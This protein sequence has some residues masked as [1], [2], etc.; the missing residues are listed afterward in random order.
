MILFLFIFNI[1]FLFNN[2]N[3]MIFTYF[4]QILKIIFL[5]MKII[6]IKNLGSLKIEL[7]SIL[8][9][10]FFLIETIILQFMTQYFL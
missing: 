1:L 10:I 2:N 6:Y 5:I 4:N 3:F 7:L 8:K 9:N